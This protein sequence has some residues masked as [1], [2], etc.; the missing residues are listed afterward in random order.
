MKYISL[1]V[2]PV[3]GSCNMNCRY[4]FYRDVSES[5]SIENLGKMSDATLETM[6][7]RVFEECEDSC[8][9]AFQG[10]EPTLAGLDFYEKLVVFQ[11]KYNT[12]GLNVTNSIQTNGLD[13]DESWA[14]FFKRE[15]FLVGV[16]IDGDKELHDTSRVDRKDKGTFS[17]ILKTVNLFNKHGVDYNILCVLTSYVARYPERVYKYFKGQ[18]FKYLQFIPCLDPLAEERGGSF[19]SLKPDRFESFLKRMFDLWYDDCIKNEGISIRHFDNWLGLLLGYPP[20][21]CAMSGRCA[22]YFVLEADGSVYPCDFYV[23][24]E[25]KMGNIATDKFVDMQQSDTAKRFVAAS[26]AL[27]NTCMECKYYYLCRGGCRRDRV[28]LSND[29]TINYYCSAFKGFFDYSL[30]RF[31]QVASMDKHPYG[32][33]NQKT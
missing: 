22:V 31:R 1:L 18:G 10:G 16:S 2:K 4:C 24:D 5:R 32:Q 28:E 8:S 11:K 19:Y 13:L 7:Q 21:N 27:D 25:W 9:F 3:S 29:K 26:G 12:K 15:N 20:E 17:R 33:T 30:D 23:T 14:E 6:V